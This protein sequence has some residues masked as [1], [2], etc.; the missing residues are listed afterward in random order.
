MFFEARSPLQHNAAAG[1]LNGGLAVLGVVNLEVEAP[2]KTFI[3]SLAVEPG[4]VNR[5]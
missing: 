2:A 5:S 4:R 1:A 3:A